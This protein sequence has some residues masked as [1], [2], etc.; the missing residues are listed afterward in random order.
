MEPKNLKDMEAGDTMMLA[1]EI[2]QRTS[3]SQIYVKVDDTTV[4]HIETGEKLELTADELVY[5]FEP[6]H[7]AK[8]P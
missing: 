3:V 4:E 1:R 8:R 2:Q 6:E 7:A 5:P